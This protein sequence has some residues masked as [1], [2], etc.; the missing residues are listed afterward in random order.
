MFNGIWTAFK[1][2]NT[3]KLT[4]ILSL[5]IPE[6][7]HRHSVAVLNLNVYHFYYREAFQNLRLRPILLTSVSGLKEAVLSSGKHKRSPSLL[8][9][10]NNLCNTSSDII[11]LIVNC[12]VITGFRNTNVLAV[13][14]Y[15]FLHRVLSDIKLARSDND[16][17]AKNEI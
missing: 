13:F 11:V 17:D 9:E 7:L 16:K 3:N 14:T 2:P 4:L 12:N 15:G 6:S 8:P 1:E 5:T 10:V